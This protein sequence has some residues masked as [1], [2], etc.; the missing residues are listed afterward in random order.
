M[1]DLMGI[2]DACRRSGHCRPTLEKW[3]AAGWLR[4]EEM[5]YGNNGGVRR[6]TT[7][8]W[9]REAKETAAH[10]PREPVRIWRE[11]GADRLIPREGSRQHRAMKLWLQGKG[12]GVL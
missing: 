6:L 1:I 3:I 2:P 5:G 12:R 4:T 11:G 10:A 7:M 9:L 8:E